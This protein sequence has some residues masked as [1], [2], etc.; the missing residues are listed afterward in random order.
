MFT[1]AFSS[2]ILKMAENSLNQDPS[3]LDVKIQ[4]GKNLSPKMRN[5]KN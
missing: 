4:Q 1:I 5:F 3:Y 2:G